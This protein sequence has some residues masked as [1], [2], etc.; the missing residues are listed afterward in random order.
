MRGFLWLSCA[1]E[2]AYS[3]VYII[4]FNLY[5]LRLGYDANFIGLLLGAGILTQSVSAYAIGHLGRTVG[6]R[7]QLI[8]GSIICMVGLTGLCVTDLL[9]QVAQ[10]PWLFVTNCMAWL[11]GTM[12][13]VAR[14]SY[15]MQLTTAQNRMLAFSFEQLAAGGAGLLGALLMMVAPFAFGALLGVPD[16]NATP[17]RLSLLVAPLTL[18][19]GLVIFLR[20]RPE[21]P[22]A[23]SELDDT[24]APAIAPR[25]DRT[26]RTLVNITAVFGLLFTLGEV[27]PRY[28]FN[29]YMDESLSSSSVWIAA[30]MGLANAAAIPGSLLLPWLGKRW[31]NERLMLAMLVLTSTMIVV[32]AVFHTELVASVSYVVLCFFLRAIEPVFEIFRMTIVPPAWQS[33]MAGTLTASTTLASAIGTMAVGD[34]TDHA[35]YRVIFIVSAGVMMVAT[36]VFSGIVARSSAR[37][38]SSRSSDSPS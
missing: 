21:L 14:L 35:S 23:P 1:F 11:G 8:A 31:S 33:R 36:L 7:P 5:L 10:T 4:I 30:T 13:L 22:A 28:F 37:S 12:V 6:P 9:P 27:A 15:L 17:Y 24:R 16:A 29:V 32:L 25:S 3:G 20:H 19:L 18:A 2:L 38:Y 26:I 34:T